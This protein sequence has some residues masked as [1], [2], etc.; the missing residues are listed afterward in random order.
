MQRHL[1]PAVDRFR[2]IPEDDKRQAVR[3]RLG[4][5]VRI[6]AFLSQIIPYADS[7]LEMLYSFARFLLPHL[8]LLDDPAVVKVTDEVD[9]N[10]YRLERVSSGPI[11][12]AEGDAHYLRSPME[13]GTGA[14]EDEKVPLSEIIKVLNERFGTQLAEEDRLFFQQIKEKASKDEQVIQTALANPIDKFELGIRKLIEDL[15]IERMAENDKLVTRYM[16]DRDFQGSAFPIL[17]REIFETVRA[18]AA[19]S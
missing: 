15:M 5:Y 2:A 6:Y 9:L 17:A 19:S 4:A 7:E 8:T 14:A 3:D 11:T 13:V 18:A 10:Y 12:L 16:E 1:Q